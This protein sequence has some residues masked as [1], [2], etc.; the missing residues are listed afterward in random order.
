ML[1]CFLIPASLAFVPSADGQVFD[2]DHPEKRGPSRVFGGFALMAAVPQGEFADQVGNGYGF[3]GNV[4][5][6]LGRSS[7]VGIRLDAGFLIYGHERKRVCF[8]STIGCRLQ[9]DLNTNNNIFVAGIGPQLMLPKG[10]VRP[11]L[12]GSVGLAYLFTESSVE[13]S[14]DLSP[15][16]NT[17]NYDDFTFAWTGAAGVYIPVRR[18]RQPISI[19]L[20]A[21][22][23]AN[24]R[25]NYLREGSIRD[26]PDGSISFTPIQSDTNF[27]TWQ[28]GLAF[29]GT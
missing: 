19:D 16:A 1:L 18:G 20:S 15:F 10:A 27:W 21:R 12:T 26:N 4:V 28:L 5:L 24:G 13:G 11:Y 14:S 29:G 6:P 25:A 22:Y 2:M 9:L 7:P 3:G 23:H 8:S 17:T